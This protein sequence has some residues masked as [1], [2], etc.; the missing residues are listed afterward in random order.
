MVSRL[1]RALAG[2]VALSL[3]WAAPRAQEA[4]PRGASLEARIDRLAAE[5]QAAEDVSAIKRLQRAYGY[6][7]DKGLWEDVA[8]LFAD[9]AV[10]NYPAGVF[11]GKTSIRQHLYM[12][13]GGGQMGDLGLGDGRLYNHMNIQPVVHLDPG[14]RTAKGR[15]RAFAMFGNFGGGAVWAEGIYNFTYVKDHGVWKIQTLDYNAG[16]G[17]PYDTGWVAPATPRRVGG[18]RELAHPADRPRNMPCEGFPAACI[19]PFHYKNPGSGGGGSVWTVADTQPAADGATGS[20]EKAAGRSGTVSP[21]AEE[22]KRIGE[23]ALSAERLYDEQQIQNLIKIYGYYVDRRLWDDVAG[24]FAADGTI[25]MGQRGVYVGKERIRAFLNLL[26]PEGLKD[27][28]LNDH[29]QLQAIVTVSRDG[30]TAK[31]RSRELGM[32]GVYQSHGE[33]S[34]GVYENT[35]VKDDGV[36]KFA[37]LRFYPTFITDYD[38]GWAK[39]AKP[40]PKAS[41]TLPPDRPPTDVYEIYPKAH[42][43]PFDYPNPVTG[44][45][46]HYPSGAGRPSERAIAAVLAPVPAPRA[47]PAEGPDPSAE[48]AEAERLVQRVKDYH[49]IE[50]LENAYG[51]YLDKN[52]WNDLA[53]LFAADGSMELAQR[54]V[55]VGR[56][57]VRG[58]LFAAF[59]PEGPVEGRLG[60]HVQM[61][62]VIDVA[63]DGQ[64]A[65]IRARMLQ[66]LSFGGRPSL[67]AAIY[68]N[69][70]VKEGGVWKFKKVHAYNTWTA[71]Y[72]GGWAKNP[73]RRVP[74]PSTTYP[75]DEPPT[76]AFEMFPTIY[77]IP[78]HYANP[79]TSAERDSG[80]ARGGAGGQRRAGVSGATPRHP[81]GMSEE[82]AAKLREIGPRIAGPETTALYAPLFPSEP[83]AGVSVERDVRYG[84]N[85]RN[86]LDVFTTPPPGS[87]KPVIVFLHGGGFARGDKHAA[88]TPFYDNVMLWAVGR[89]FVGVNV[90]YRLA[91]ESMWPS[92]IEDL[93]AVTDWL[94]EHAA[95]YGGDP[96]AVFLWGH[97][98]GAAHVADYIAHAA[99][100][101]RGAKIA[102]AI[103][104]SGFYDLGQEV[105]VWKAY[106]GDDVSTY[107]GR[108]SLPGLLETSVPLLV[109][110]AEL[111]PEMFRS[112]TE[113]LVNGRKKIG[114]PVAYVHLPNHSHLSE[115]YAIG[116]EDHSLSAPV[117]E[118]VKGIAAS[119]I[120]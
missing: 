53:D 10:A 83:Y 116:T 94:A 22:R 105:S 95:E 108:S 89:G 45:P 6:Y 44:E 49:E 33:W 34:E 74:G 110:D 64:S 68:E 63:P 51:Y 40:V 90:N 91:P 1:A 38:K 2:A 12:N 18:R 58:F 52:L 70:A 11:I 81:D 32:T 115:T 78:F 86:V 99:R 31:A 21:S 25:E 114:K 23:L 35:F 14:G 120:S 48:L 88:G 102:G 46:P 42:I 43:P 7:V 109:T 47:A 4:A 96:K 26:G 15:W 59:G 82:V 84:P 66:Q 119:A 97:S 112:E 60:N 56:E 41:E 118:F 113:K 28:D 39:D 54:G 37:S 50:N 24:L 13:V 85:E 107:A 98:A 5:L 101:G 16:F 72:A 87:G 62:H 27:G 20:G 100:A 55:Y 61:Q 106:Y 75:P 65:K 17:A 92:G 77:D 71:S 103:L 79:V 104:T 36:W 19:A 67:G 73:G 80:P 93:A 30:R 117:A 9:D 69:E 111:D 76:T 29:V 8:Q 3:L 57:R